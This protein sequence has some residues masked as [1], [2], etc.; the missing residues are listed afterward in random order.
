MNFLKL[1]TELIS[2]ILYGYYDG[3]SKS[4]LYKNS[5]VIKIY[6]ENV[7]LHAFK[8][9]PY[10]VSSYV[11]ELKSK[12]IVFD[13]QYE[14]Q[15]AKN[16][17]DYCKTLNK[18]IDR[19]ILSHYHFDHWLGA[20]VFKDEAPIFALNET[21]DQIN[22]IYIKR[23][24]NGFK[25][26]AVDFLKYV[27]VIK[28][29]SENIDGVEFIFEKILNGEN[30]ITL[31]TRMPCIK[32]MIVGDLVYNKF[33]MYVGEVVNIDT[34]IAVLEYFQTNFLY[35]HIL[36]GHG[37]PV[38]QTA[39]YEN[40]NYLKYVKSVSENFKTLDEYRSSIFQKY[41]NYGNPG[42]VNC[43]FTNFTCPYGTF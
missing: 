5:T 10:V 8:P 6:E 21:I 16:F 13:M 26:A 22:E 23:K 15:N 2:L 36:V 28:E 3:F 25:L 27:K 32:T 43:P 1:L 42:I 33:Y 31:I 18:P 39:F 17:L 37:D 12:L 29:H 34:W 7:V 41:P 9:E 40:I 11:V 4:L 30:P 38:G 14:T 24:E 19:I 20:S 35:N